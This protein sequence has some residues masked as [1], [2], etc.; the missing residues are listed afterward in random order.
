MSL[1]ARDIGQQSDIV[2][3]VD[4]REMRLSQRSAPRR[5]PR[6]A[7]PWRSRRRCRARRL[8]RQHRL[9]GG[10][11]AGLLEG[12]RQLAGLHLARFDVGL[13]ERIDA[14]DRARDG[15]RDLEA[16][17]FLADMLGGFLHDADDRVSGRF[18]RRQLGLVFRSPLAGE[19]QVDEEAVLP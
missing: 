4:P 5:H 14:D 17:E 10:Q 9:L 15:G 8:C 19:P 11:R 16:E 18:Q 3:A 13:I 2:A 12:G 6:R 7:T 1:V